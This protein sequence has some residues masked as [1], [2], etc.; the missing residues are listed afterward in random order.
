[1]PFA[2]VGQLDLSVKLFPLLTGNIEVE[3]LEL[4]RPEIELIRNAQGVWNFSTAGNAPV[5]APNQPTPEPTTAA[6]ETRAWS[7]LRR[8]GFTL[9]ELKITDGQIAVTDDQK[10]QPRAV[11]DHI[12]VTLKDYAP[13]KPFSLDAD[14]ASAGQR[15]ADLRLTGDGGPVNNADFASTPF[16]GTV[17]WKRSRSR[18]RRSF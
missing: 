17:R 12:D 16:K 9:G 3:S 13:G 11:Y 1:M 7:A 2:Q 4:K 18:A 5:P 6:S 8:G 10:H 15:L 14:G